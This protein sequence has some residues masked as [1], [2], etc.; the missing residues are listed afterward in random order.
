MCSLW[1]DMLPKN[2]IHTLLLS[3]LLEITTILLHS[4]YTIHFHFINSVKLLF[5]TSQLAFNLLKNKRWVCFP[6]CVL[7]SQ[8]LLCLGSLSLFCIL[9]SFSV[10]ILSKLIS[11]LLTSIVC[12]AWTCTWTMIYYFLSMSVSVTW[13]PTGTLVIDNNCSGFS[14]FY[15][16]AG[17]FSA[18]F[19]RP[20]SCSCV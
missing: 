3:V 13:E 16:C 18:G 4:R 8:N 15:G 11:P 9:S 17:S 12:R 19:P 6:S 1:N 5:L 14:H 10:Q 2:R 20:H 7:G